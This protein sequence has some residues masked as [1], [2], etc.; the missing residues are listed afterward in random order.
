VLGD[1]RLAVS[2]STLARHKVVAAYFFQG[3]N[4]GTILLDI[5]EVPAERVFE[6]ERERFQRNR[7]YSW[8]GSW[9]DSDSSVMAH[10]AKTGVR[11]YVI[12]SA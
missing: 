12:Q 8:P 2:S 10:I 4:L 9:N 1:Y 7:T 3:D 5:A 11:A 6:Q